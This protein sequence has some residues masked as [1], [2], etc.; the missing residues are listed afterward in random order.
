MA[1]VMA[2]VFAD[3]GDSVLV[4]RGEDGL[5]EFSTAAPTRLWIAHQGRVTETLADAAD[6]G[7][8]RSAPGDLRGGDAAFNA[9]VARRL[10]AGEP[11]PVRDA[12]LVNSAAALATQGGLGGDLRSAM[13]DGLRRAAESVD[14]GAAAATLDR[15]VDVAQAAKAAE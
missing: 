8:A 9:D 11:G 12:V 10:F 3:R 2:G 14:S 5:D 1:G 13:R 6:L 7:V 15:W 4:M